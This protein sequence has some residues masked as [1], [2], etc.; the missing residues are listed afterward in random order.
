MLVLCFEKIN[1]S[2]TNVQNSN[3]ENVCLENK[4]NALQMCCRT[5]PEK[6]VYG[7][8]FLS[9]E[10]QFNCIFMCYEIILDNR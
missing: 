9:Y 8:G 1:N 7:H 6:N 4:K 10:C 5:Q 3:H 2:A